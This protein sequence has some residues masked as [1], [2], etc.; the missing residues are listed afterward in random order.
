M[1]LAMFLTWLLVAIVTGGVASI[2]VKRP[3][4][5]IT[6]DVL[7]TLV[8]SGLLCSALAATGVFGE[9]SA[10]SIGVIAFVGAGA[11][12]AVQRTLTAAPS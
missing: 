7:L 11:A 12:I 6:A 9:A 2:A 1:T 8:G 4:H 5:G 10:T 3:G